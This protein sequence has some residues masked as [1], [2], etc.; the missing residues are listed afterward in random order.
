M[1]NYTTG[2][3]IIGEQSQFRGVEICQERD[4]RGVKLKGNRLAWVKVDR[5][6]KNWEAAELANALLMASAPELLEALI[7]CKTLLGTVA[8]AE[9]KDERSREAIDQGIAMAG[10]AIL[11]VRGRSL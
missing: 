10:R 1:S 3:W 6:A 7:R 4:I 9:V 5:R 8:W 11:K 2:K